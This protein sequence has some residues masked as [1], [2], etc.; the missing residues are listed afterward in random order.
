MGVI[1]GKKITGE[2]IFGERDSGNYLFHGDNK[3]VLDH[4]AKDYR[5]KIKCIYIDPPYNN[6]DNYHYN[7]NK[8]HEEWLAEVVIV[9]KKLHPL[10]T[11]DGSIWI[12]IDDNEMPY[13]KVAADKVFGRENYVSTIIWQQR[14]S[15]ENRSTFSNNHEYILV[16]ANDPELFKA[17]RNLLPLTQTVLSR[18]K[19]PD[20]D[21]R[22]AWQSVSAN[23]QAGHGT[24]SQFYTVKSPSG[25]LHEPPNGRCWVYNKSRMG[26]EIESNNIWFGKDGSGV[27]RIKKFLNGAKKGLTPQTLWMAEDVGT[28]DEA[29]KHFLDLFLKEGVFETPKPERLIS[30]IL[31]IASNEGDL[32]LDCY[33]G[34]GSTAST[35]IKMGRRF[36]GIE[37]DKKIVDFAVKR[38]SKVLE[39]EQGGISKE[40]K[41][42]KGGGF[43]F[44]RILNS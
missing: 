30:R 4:L 36:I 11:E 14:T 9:L 3:I 5:K 31:N 22:G 13:L 1:S 16:Y 8:S 23:V 19:N 10:M 43:D 17:S 18:Y 42:K 27:P 20:N 26:K 15:R 12:S 41:W 35:A 2:R 38:L 24:A 44:Y 25:L 32:V 33:L 6:K 34:S 21:I 39:G 40:F 29:K 28:N 37:Y 7:D